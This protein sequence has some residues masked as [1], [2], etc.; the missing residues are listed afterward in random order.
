ML[1]C[2]TPSKKLFIKNLKYRFRKEG[3]EEGRKGGR[4]ELFNN[5]LKTFYLWLYGIRYIVGVLVKARK[6]KLH[7]IEIQCFIMIS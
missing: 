1:Y 6:S 3:R 7:Q 5:A 4:K 2:C